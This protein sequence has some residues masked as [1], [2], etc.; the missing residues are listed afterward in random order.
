[1]VDQGKLLLHGQ[2]WP[3]SVGAVT[4]QAKGGSTGCLLMIGL[5]V[6]VLANAHSLVPL[7][8]TRKGNGAEQ[9]AGQGWVCRALIQ[10]EAPWCPGQPP[11]LKGML[12][13]ERCRG[14]VELCAAPELQTWGK[15]GMEL[16]LTFEHFPEN[17][18]LG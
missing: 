2:D 14:D 11:G 18:V 12:D 10:E 4:R 8:R 9:E 3:G 6:G 17:L 5:G 15:A 1:M 7:A 16:G 13:L